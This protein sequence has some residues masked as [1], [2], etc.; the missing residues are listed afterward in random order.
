[1]TK[2]YLEILSVQNIQPDFVHEITVKKEETSGGLISGEEPGDIPG[3]SIGGGV[4]V[5]AP[6]AGSANTKQ[7]TVKKTILGY[8]K[9]YNERPVFIKMPYWK[10]Y[11]LPIWKIQ[12]I[13]ET[14]TGD[15]VRTVILYPKGDRSYKYSIAKAMTKQYDDVLQFC[16]VI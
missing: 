5:P 13:I 16:L 4:A 12:F 9:S 14:T 2:S 11:K 8:L 15:G 10:L 7:T 6:V 3:I 1:M